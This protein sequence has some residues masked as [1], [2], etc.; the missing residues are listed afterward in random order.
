VT[1]DEFAF[2]DLRVDGTLMPWCSA[3]EQDGDMSVNSREARTMKE[4]DLKRAILES[5]AHST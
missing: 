1:R 3:E 2:W 4:K 5:Q